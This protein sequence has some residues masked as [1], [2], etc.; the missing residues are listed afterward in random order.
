MPQLTDFAQE[1]RNLFF[2]V[3]VDSLRMNRHFHLFQWLR[4]D[5]QRFMPHEIL[6]GAVGDFES[7]DFKLD[8]I[9][10]M[11][12]VRT[13][14]LGSCTPDVNQLVKSFYEQWLNN[15]MHPCHLDFAGNWPL[16]S[17]NCDIHMAVRSMKSVL[18]N[19][20]R[21]EREGYDSL[22]MIFLADDQPVKGVSAILEFLTPHIDMIMRKFASMPHGNKSLDEVETGFALSKREVQIL[23]WVSKGKTN[24]EIGNILHISE[25]TVKN[26]LP[27]IFKKLG[28][29]NRAQAVSTFKRLFQEA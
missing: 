18:F 26:H 10:A 13:E 4:G 21:N 2:Q 20:L 1:E 8:V 3:V 28:V 27:R 12:G 15:D 5:L 22:Y 24:I 7:G 23:E 29:V 16:G 19:G 11:P 17:C 14:H 6:L 9:S 25:F